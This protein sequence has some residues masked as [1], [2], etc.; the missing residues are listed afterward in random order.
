M[1]SIYDLFEPLYG[2]RCFIEQEI[3][4]FMLNTTFQKQILE[5]G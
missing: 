3:G 1:S 5:R 4:A 2:P